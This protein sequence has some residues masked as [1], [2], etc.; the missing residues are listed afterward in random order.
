VAWLYNDTQ[1]RV[2]ATIPGFGPTSGHNLVTLLG[3]HFGT[4]ENTPSQESN[5]Y[6]P[7]TTAYRVR[8]RVSLGDVECLSTV[9]VS[10]SEIVCEAPPGIGG[11]AAMVELL[12]DDSSRL[13]SART[14]QTEV[15][16]TKAESEPKTWGVDK[17][18]SR[19]TSPRHT[20]VL[21]ETTKHGQHAEGEGWV[22]HEENP[23]LENNTGF[24]NT[25]LA[26][27]TGFR[28]VFKQQAGEPTDEAY[29]VVVPPLAENDAVMHRWRRAGALPHG[30]AYSQVT[31][32]L[33]GVMVP[34]AATQRASGFLALS[35]SPNMPGTL[36]AP[37]PSAQRSGLFLSHGVSA[38]AML[39]GKLFAGGSFHDAYR[40]HGGGLKG[41]A[42]LSQPSDF[43]S[44]AQKPGMVNVSV[45]NILAFDGYEVSSLG[46]GADGE[47]LALSV[48][49][50]S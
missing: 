27:C 33:G 19:L 28:T 29:V 16:E 45:G 11:G 21:L 6:A 24:R 46:V 8:R 32:F 47:V 15:N 12:D 17:G 43:R 34:Q 14:L 39:R 9:L 10:D 2:F 44:R 40:K 42:W 30:L 18:F 7:T 41:L 25:T 5:P 1:P 23:T 31:L 49:Q 38:F 37:A 26:N 20:T 50:V 22:C 13:P 35:P 3:Q 48:F 36:A 4:R